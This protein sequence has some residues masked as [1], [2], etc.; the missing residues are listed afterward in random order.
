[1]ELIS[2][3]WNGSFLGSLRSK[4]QDGSLLP[5]TFE[6]FRA[7]NSRNF[8]RGFSRPLLCGA[9]G[10]SDGEQ[11]PAGRGSYSGWQW[12][13]GGSMH[14]GAQARSHV[15]PSVLSTEYAGV[16]AQRSSTVASQRSTLEVKR[17]EAAGDV[18]PGP[19]ATRPAPRCLH[20][21]AEYAS[22]RG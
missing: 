5:R 1:M 10:M 6:T 22:G 2:S 15:D 4:G 19:C 13:E 9:A 14:Y 16:A 7:V 17:E 12:A 3:F 21:P 8:D 20:D 11:A 18:L